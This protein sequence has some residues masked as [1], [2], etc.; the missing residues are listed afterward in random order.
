MAL[1]HF[2]HGCVRTSTGGAKCWGSNS[3][4][5][6]GDGTTD[7]RAQPITVPLSW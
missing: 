4:G 7:D 3:K 5:Q 6:L 2:A 1:G